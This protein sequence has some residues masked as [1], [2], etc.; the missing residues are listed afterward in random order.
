MQHE[1]KYE[2]L[3]HDESFKIMEEILAMQIGLSSDQVSTEFL[4]VFF[5]S[6]SKLTLK[7]TGWLRD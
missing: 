5:H 3:G 6:G 4:G 2:P 7:G 1:S